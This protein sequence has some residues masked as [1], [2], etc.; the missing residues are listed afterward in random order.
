MLEQV[1][2][3]KG[4]I[5][6]KD[7]FMAARWHMV[8]NIRPVHAEL[9]ERDRR[10]GMPG[11]TGIRNPKFF[12]AKGYTLILLYLFHTPRDNMK[13]HGI[14]P[15]EKLRFPGFCLWWGATYSRR[16]WEEAQVVD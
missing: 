13:Q 12:S 4:K 6:G 11:D 8:K 1:P 15:G 9:Y 3:G 2:K 14:A 10:P 16:N 7:Y 5:Q